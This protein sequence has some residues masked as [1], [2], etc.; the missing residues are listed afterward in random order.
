MTI[1][2][3]IKKLEDY[4]QGSHS[5]ITIDYMIKLLKEVKKNK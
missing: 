3:I 1:E 5:V 4:K 2:E